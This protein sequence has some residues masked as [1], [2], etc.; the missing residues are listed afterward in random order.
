MSRVLSRMTF[1]G[2]GREEASEIVLT[3]FPTPMGREGGSG[4][5]D[6]QRI[7]RA[8]RLLSRVGPTTTARQAFPGPGAGSTRW[9]PRPWVEWPSFPPQD[10]ARDAENPGDPRRG[11]EHA[12][13]GPA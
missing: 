3:R 12:R 8:R 13:Q 6:H 10:G 9:S 5:T 4:A 11:H 1:P 7:T 2:S